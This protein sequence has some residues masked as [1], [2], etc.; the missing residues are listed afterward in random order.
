MILLN[1]NECPFCSR[2][3]VNLEEHLKTE[4]FLGMSEYYEMEPPQTIKS[5][6]Y[7]HPLTYI[8]PTLYYLPIWSQLRSTYEKNQAAQGCQEAIHDYVGKII[9][10]RYLQMF[11]VND[12]YFENTLTHTYEEFRNVLRK[13]RQD[14]NKIWFLDWYPGFPKIICDQNVDGIKTV[15]I[16]DYYD[17]KEDEDKLRINGWHVDGPN[18]IPYDHRHHGRYNIFN[19]SRD[20]TRGTKRMRFTGNTSNCMK[21]NNSPEGFKSILRAKEAHHLNEQDLTVTKLILLRN[22]PIMRSIGTVIDEIT[23]QAGVF[24]DSAFLRNTVWIDPR[25]DNIKVNLSWLPLKKNYREG[26]INISIL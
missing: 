20:T 25:K 14:R 5:S 2:E 18:Y 6:K 7:H 17:V 8:D 1:S 13:K 26:F 24:S 9:S 3:A 21:F 19:L 15:L 10:D 16:D 23:K 12:F 11:L 4:H 22:K